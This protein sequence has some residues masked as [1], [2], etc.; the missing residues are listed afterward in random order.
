MLT[1]DSASSAN[2]LLSFVE[3]TVKPVNNSVSVNSVSHSRSGVSVDN[4]SVQNDVAAT[5]LPATSPPTKRKLRR[6]YPTKMQNQTE[7]ALGS[8]QVAQRYKGKRR[9]VL[10]PR[11]QPNAT[12]QATRNMSAGAV[13][14]LNA[15]NIP[16]NVRKPQ[17]LQ[18]RQRQRQLQQQKQQSAQQQRQLQRPDEL[19]RTKDAQLQQQI[20]VPPTSHLQK[21]YHFIPQPDTPATTLRISTSIDHHHHQQI[22]TNTTTT[23]RQHIQQQPPQGPPN[24]H[25]YEHRQ[26]QQQQQQQHTVSNSSSIT[27]RHQHTHQQQPQSQQHTVYDTTTIQNRQDHVVVQGNTDIVVYR[28]IGTL[29]CPP[30]VR[31]VPHRFIPVH[32]QQRT[33]PREIY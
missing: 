6:K 8:T 20:R 12:A 33:R 14:R 26:Q 31:L 10:L 29:P 3:S 9:K 5:M 1:D 25:R 15:E 2:Q 27:S 4:E 23:I 30:S 32:P 22:T 13:Q 24:E 21:Q 16:K 18:E 17:T 19:K 11:G 7:R 28:N